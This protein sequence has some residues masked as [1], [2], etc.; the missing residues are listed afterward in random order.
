MHFFASGVPMAA[1][2]MFGLRYRGYPLI[3]LDCR[4]SV[5]HVRISSI[6]IRNNSRPKL[7]G[8]QELR[9]RTELAFICEIRS[10]I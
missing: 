10:G 2:G 7:G 4:K 6:E 1:F 3:C 5:H 9:C 8:A